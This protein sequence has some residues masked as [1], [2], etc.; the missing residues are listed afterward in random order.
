MPLRNWGKKDAKE[1]GTLNAWNRSFS[2]AQ[3]G[4]SSSGDSLN[5]KSAT[6]TTDGLLS[7]IDSLKP[8]LGKL[9]RKFPELS[10]FEACLTTWQA[11]LKVSQRLCIC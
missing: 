11:L 10:V 7:M 8:F 9:V 2:V 5:S 4:P 1:C 3:L 6:A